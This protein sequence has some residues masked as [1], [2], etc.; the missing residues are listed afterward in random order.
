MDE[1]K[2]HLRTPGRI[3]KPILKGRLPPP[4][5]FPGPVL[6]GLA[7]FSSTRGRFSK[8]TNVERFITAIRHKEPDHV[9]CYPM[10]F[11]ACRRLAGVSYP[12][13]ALNAKSA[14]ESLLA[15][16]ELIGG[17]AVVP[18]LDLSLEAADFGQKMVYPQNSTPHPDYAAPL[19]KDIDDYRKLKRIDLQNAQ[20]MQAML[21]MCRILVERVGLRGAVSGFAFGPLGVLNMMR[22]TEY[23]FR[24]CILHPSEVMA[25]LNTITEVLIEYVEAQCDTGV[26]AVTLDTLFA[27]W[28]G[29]SKELWEKIEGPFAREIANAIHRRGCV[30]IVHNCGDG[31]YFDSQIRFM[32]PTIISFAQLP[33]DCSNR[34]EL[35][36]RYGDQVVLMGYIS[37][38]L[39]SYGTPYEVMQEC[40]MQIEDL[41]HGGGFVLA[42]GCEFPPNAPLENAMAIVKAAELYG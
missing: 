33:D 35:K 15:G 28:N 21:E 7:L 13:F 38:A 36:R 4:D 2:E 3:I 18:M 19:I 9:P 42:P 5:L 37:T 20:R 1:K 40:R 17:E 10:M 34:K 6:D 22:G 41:A 23:L 26:L 12:D 16:F 32:E 25:A 29:L 31:V 24:D 14:S 30:V 11:G 8:L 39:L 27:S